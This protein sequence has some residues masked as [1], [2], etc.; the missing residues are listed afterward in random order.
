VI[1]DSPVDLSGPAGDIQADKMIIGQTDTSKDGQV[2]SRYIRFEGNVKV[3]I[4]PESVKKT[5][6]EQ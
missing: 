1:T 6:A 4:Q 2:E 5:N 3:F